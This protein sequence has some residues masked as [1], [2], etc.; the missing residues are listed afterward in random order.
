MVSVAAVVLADRCPC[1]VADVDDCCVFAGVRGSALL[2][3][4]RH[5]A[6]PSTTRHSRRPHSAGHSEHVRYAQEQVRSAFGDITAGKVE[7]EQQVGLVLG[8]HHGPQVGAVVLVTPGVGTCGV[9]RES[10]MRFGR[11][12]LPRPDPRASCSRSGC[13]CGGVRWAQLVAVPVPSDASPPITRCYGESANRDRICR[14]EGGADRM[15]RN[16]HSQPY[17]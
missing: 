17:R 1:V 4:C 12:V 13:G 7:D 15:S 3:V 9:R 10:T 5:R 2:L 6:T 11:A 8:P 14:V 16:V